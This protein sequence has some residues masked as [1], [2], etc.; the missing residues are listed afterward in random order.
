MKFIIKH[1]LPGRIRVHFFLKRMSFKEADTLQYYLQGFSYVS[2]AK[3][4]ERTADAVIRYGCTR[5]ELIDAL[6]R[7]HFEKVE[8]PESVF[9]T[10]GRE[11]NAKYYEK[12]VTSIVLHYGKRLFMPMPLRMGWVGFKTMRYMW[13]GIRTIPGRKLKVEL[14]DA[15]AIAAS[16]LMG[17]YKTA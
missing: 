11:L 2:E 6:R 5:D 4:Y 17:D 16:M 9:E 14:L 13:R 8:V 7:F 3:V 1:E 10:S 12:L 15:I